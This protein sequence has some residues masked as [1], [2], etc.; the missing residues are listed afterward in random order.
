MR[1]NGKPT[2]GFR[3]MRHYE[4]EQRS[5]SILKKYGNL[6]SAVLSG[7]NLRQS[8]KQVVSN[9]G[10]GGVDGMS[11]EELPKHLSRN[12]HRLKSELMDGTYRPQSVKGVS[13]PKPNGGKRLLGIPTVTD[14]FIQQA[15]HQVLSRLYEREF[16]EFSYGFRPNRSAH[17]ALAKA[18]EHINAGYDEVIDLDLKSFFD[19]VNHD[20]LMGLLRRRIS[21][22]SLLRLIRRYLQSGI[23]MDKTLQARREGTPQGGPLSP[24]LSNILLNELDKE[25]EKRGHRFIRYAD[26][27]SIFVRSKRAAERV[28]ESITRFLN[29]KLLLEVNEE[30][31]S[32]CRPINFKLLGHGFVPIYKK[33]VRGQ[34][35]LSIAKKSW[36]RLK[37]KIKFIT[38]KTSPIPFAER[39]DHLNELMRGWVHYFKN[40]TGYQK[41]KDLDGWIRSRLRYCIWKM[42]KRPKR[43]L[44]AFLQLGMS[45]SWARRFAYSRRGGWR[46][47][48]SPV[49]K[50]TVTEERLRQRGYIP[51]L[52]YYLKVR[53][54]QK[55]TKK[56]VR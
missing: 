19:H 26:D 37:M 4:D 51:F 5:I 28:L 17:D 32:I 41:L 29:R 49:M 6:M 34:Y 22:R 46:L 31:T 13:I 18:N 1:S 38:R 33:G 2:G 23:L 11:V 43:R 9:K 10:A 36:E 21:D 16:S 48:C 42:W 14:R 55:N 39:I 8:L 52:E 56:S 3:V 53:N 54:T 45:P 15:I 7:L 25:L 30:K 40:A 24:L 12:L 27:V 35:R 47:S 44:R 20:K 50:M